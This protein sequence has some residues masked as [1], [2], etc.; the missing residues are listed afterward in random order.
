MLQNGKSRVRDLVRGMTFLIY[1]IPPAALDTPGYSAFNRN[2]Y[3]KQK[4]MFLGNKERP[5]VRLTTLPPSVSRLSRQCGIVNIS[6][7]YR[8]PRPV[9]G[10]AL[11]YGDG[12]CFL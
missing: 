2:E 3:H 10:I 9:T 1:L 4:I 7:P 5:C 11:L 12:V 6:Q 8:A